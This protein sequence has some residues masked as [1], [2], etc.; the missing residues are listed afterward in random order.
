MAKQIPWEWLY[1][2][3]DDDDTRR[4]LDEVRRQRDFVLENNRFVSDDGLFSLRLGGRRIWLR[5]CSAFSQ[6]EVY[7]ELFRH[8]NHF[9]ATDFSGRHAAVVI[10]LGAN[11]GYYVLKVKEANPYCRVFALEPNPH[12]FELL[13]RNLEANGL[14]DVVL[15]NRAVAAEDGRMALPIVKGMPAICGQGL[16]QVAR[17]WLKA[18]FVETMPV[19]AMSL[20]S[21]WRVSNLDTVDILKIDVEGMETEVLQGAGDLLPKIH[22]IVVECHS[23]FSR[24]AVAVFMAEKGFDLV[25]EED[26]EHANYYGDLYFVN[27]EA[28]RVRA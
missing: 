3:A 4:L 26:P 8:D 5:W 25:L 7:C 22:R 24:E 15:L 19:D 1:G 14:T 17:P 11:E 21:L 18:D 16:F 12:S 2:E 20:A 10:D 13:E 28:E 27:P 6:I 9:L 23:P